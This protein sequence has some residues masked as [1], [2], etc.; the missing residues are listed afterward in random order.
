MKTLY[1]D[2][3]G[4]RRFSALYAMVTLADGRRV[5][6]ESYYQSVKRTK[7][8]GPA[9][10]GQAV[11]HIIIKGKRYSPKYLTP[12]YRKLWVMYF[13]QNPELFE[14]A[15]QHTNFIDRFKGRAINCQADVIAD[16]VQ[17]GDLK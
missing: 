9:K 16:L 7:T 3:R 13:Q 15:K 11:D 8:G 2:S 4:D 5:S 12:L 17:K 10:K 1:C 14:Y 6:I